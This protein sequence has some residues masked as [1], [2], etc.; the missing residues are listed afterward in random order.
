[1]GGGRNSTQRSL[2][3]LRLSC[4][5]FIAL[6]LHLLFYSISFYSQFFFLSFTLFYQSLSAQISYFVFD[7]HHVASAVFCF[8]F[9]FAFANF[10]T[11]SYSIVLLHV[12]PVNPVSWRSLFETFIV[13][14]CG[15][16]ST[17]PPIF[18]LLLSLTRSMYFTIR[19]SAWKCAIVFLVIP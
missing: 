19:C 3:T 17:R 7:V 10:H 12:W 14:V 8:A 11:V 5:L 6:R 1:M 2:N 18:C 16:T 13:D 4:N 15:G 9:A